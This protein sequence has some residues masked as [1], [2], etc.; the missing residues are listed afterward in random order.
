MHAELDALRLHYYKHK[1]FCH[2]CA[3]KELQVLTY[4]SLLSF[5]PNSAA[6][7]TFAFGGL[8]LLLSWRVVH[9]CLLVARRDSSPYGASCLQWSQ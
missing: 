7:S 8:L 1:T 6:N 4:C 2:R 5:V 3:S 9:L